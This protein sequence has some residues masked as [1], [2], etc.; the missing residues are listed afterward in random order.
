MNRL[1]LNALNAPVFVL[2][3]AIGI[4]I[5]TSL[6]GFWPLQYLQPNIVLVAVIWCALRRG[7]LEG[8]IITLIISDLSELHSAAPQGLYLIAFMTV[9]LGVRAA[10]KLVVIPNVTG[11]VLV[12]L[13]A[14]IAWKFV[15]LFTLYLLGASNNQW[16]HTF[17]FLFPGAVIEASIGI[18]VFRLFESFDRATFKRVAV[19]RAHGS[20][21]NYDD[22][23]MIEGIE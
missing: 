7:F 4:A 22:E 21:D 19:D 1:I 5:Q 16:R 2:L 14:S 8:G 9:F 3:I 13:F 11:Y 12:T 20:S 17:L 18:W 15:T 23:F 6:F 10:S